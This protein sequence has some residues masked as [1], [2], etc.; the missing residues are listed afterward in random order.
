MEKLDVQ[1]SSHI[2]TTNKLT[3]NVL[4]ARCPSCRSTNSGMV[5][6]SLT[7]HSTQYKSFQRREQ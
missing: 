2:V 1:S 7:S 6:Y 4:Q 3:R 5:Y